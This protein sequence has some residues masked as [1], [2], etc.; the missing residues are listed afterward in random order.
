[1]VDR[2][3]T[4]SGPAGTLLCRLC[5]LLAISVPAC[6]CLLAMYCLWYVFGGGGTVVIGMLHLGGMLALERVG[7]QRYE[8]LLYYVGFVLMG[9]VSFLVVWTTLLA[10]WPGWD[11]DR[12]VLPPFPLGL[13]GS[14]CFSLTL[15][16]CAAH[17]R[18]VRAS[19]GALGRRAP[20]IRN[21]D[22]LLLLTA[23]MVIAGILGVIHAATDPD[24]LVLAER[25]A[26]F[27][28]VAIIGPACG[29]FLALPWFSLPFGLRV[30]RR[31]DGVKGE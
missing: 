28:H 19:R 29:L 16:Q 5:V 14:V 11:L 21:A 24:A 17:V 7:K 13:L 20:A 30:W 26:D 25:V 15:W 31:D 4:G 9:A 2:R 18:Y 8:A 22:S 23:P 6:Y 3:T 10:T 27:C 12:H 1:M